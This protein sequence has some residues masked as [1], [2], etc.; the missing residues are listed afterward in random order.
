MQSAIGEARL[1]GW[2]VYHTHDSRRSEA[3]F[4]DI[5]AVHPRSRRLLFLECK[6]ERGRTTDA[7]AAWL[8]ALDAVREME[9]FVLRPSQRDD[10]SAI[11]SAEPGDPRAVSL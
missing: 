3:G 11:L 8:E 9:V 7:Q 4:P 10:V 1:R 6:S 5:V 2:L